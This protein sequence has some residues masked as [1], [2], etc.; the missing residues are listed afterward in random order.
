VP[1]ADVSLLKQVVN[2][3]DQFEFDVVNAGP[4][5]LPEGQPTAGVPLESKK[6]REGLAA[7]YSLTAAP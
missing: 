6:L 3:L 5:A 1:Q 2:L 7:A 4:L